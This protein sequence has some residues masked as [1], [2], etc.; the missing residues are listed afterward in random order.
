MRRV[1]LFHAGLVQHYR[2]GV[3]N[4]LS[5]FLKNR[6]F[7]LTIISEGNQSGFEQQIEFPEVILNFSLPLL[8]KM[9]R[10]HQPWATILFINHREKYFFPFLFYLRVSGNKVIT[11]THGINLQDKGSLTS[12]LAHHLEHSLCDRIVLY[13]APLKAYLLKSHRPKAYVANNTLNLLDFE[14]GKVDRQE[15]LSK[16][17]INTQKN[18]VYSGRITKRK[19]IQDLLSA[20]ELIKDENIGLILLGPDDDKIL[21]QQIFDKSRLYYLGPVYGRETLEI[22]SASDVCCIPGAIGLGI[23]DAMYCGLPVVTEKVPHGPEF[24]YFQ[25]G[26]TGYMV[27]EGDI[28]SLAEKL[29]VL[30]TD[31]DL[32][33]KMGEK[34]RKEIMINGHV[35][36]LA[37]GFL[38]CL[39]SLEE[40]KSP[41]G[42]QSEK[43]PK[44]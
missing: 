41:E 24:I 33:T 9:V 14:P 25:D 8:I 19:R 21:G 17:N 37:Q 30:L 5:A 15:T 32:R 4:Y 16:H 23:V 35:D 11:W 26:L 7:E 6:G 18:I 44:N 34:A 42:V 31:D 22:L 40:G 27:P 1:F 20:F 3:Y 29:K 28:A 36:R 13:S 38:E 39:E 43:V 2:I 12:R 10:N